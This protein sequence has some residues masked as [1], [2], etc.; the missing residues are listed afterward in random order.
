MSGFKTF[1]KK[2][3]EFDRNKRLQADEVSY[4]LNYTE[5]EYIKAFRVPKYAPLLATLQYSAYVKNMNKRQDLEIYEEE[6]L[7]AMRNKESWYFLGGG[8]K[9]L[10]LPEFENYRKEFFK[11]H[12]E[13]MQRLRNGGL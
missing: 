4:K 12:D 7:K 10:T 13:I 1:Y 3:S 5:E 11:E 8:D 9:Q 2:Y 6:Y